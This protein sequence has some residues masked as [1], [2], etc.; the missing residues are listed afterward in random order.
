MKKKEQKITSAIVYTQENAVTN[1]RAGGSRF[2][3][4]WFVFKQENVNEILKST[5]LNNR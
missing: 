4:V 3:F 5:N 1:Q 2:F